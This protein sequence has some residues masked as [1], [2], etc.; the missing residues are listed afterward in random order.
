M[1]DRIKQV[2][3]WTGLSQQ[4]FATKL[5]ISPA[6]LSSIYN[7]RTNPTNNH[8]QAIHRS[9]PEIDINWLLFGEGEMFGK[10][11]VS[12]S[13]GET[14]LRAGKATGEV[15]INT[16]PN[17]SNSQSGSFQQ[18]SIFPDEAFGCQSD[19]RQTTP[20]ASSVPSFSSP[21]KEELALLQAKNKLMESM[22]KV[23]KAPRKIKEIRVFFDDGTYESFAPSTK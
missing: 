1:K 9:F 22:N 15:N 20:A 10:A 14:E 2:M 17:A 3:E 7:G 13:F 4:D 6:S 8:V 19:V 18:G 23:D 12:P 5:G 11:S 21:L 16:I